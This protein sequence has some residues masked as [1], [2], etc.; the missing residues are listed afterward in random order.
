[1]HKLQAY[2]KWVVKQIVK[3]FGHSNIVGVR[4]EV[5][6][7]DINRPKGATSIAVPVTGVTGGG[8]DVI[9]FVTSFRALGRVVPFQPPSSLGLKEYVGAAA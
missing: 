8:H 9:E 5:S 6:L 3:H 1:M 7:S 4:G 2:M